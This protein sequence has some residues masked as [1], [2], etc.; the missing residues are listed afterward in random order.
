MGAEATKSTRSADPSEIEELRRLLLPRERARLERVERRLEGQVVTADQVGAVIADAIAAGDASHPDLLDSALEDPVSRAMRRSVRD[1]PQSVADALFPVMG[2]AIRRAIVE[3][4]RGMLESTNRAIEASLSWQGLQWRIEAWRS[5]RSFAEIVLL[6]SLIYRVEQLLLIHKETGLLVSHVVGPEVAAQHPDLVSAM[7]TAIRDFVRDSFGS[8]SG[9]TLHEF[10]VGER[11]VLVEDSPHAALAAVVRGHSPP[12][13]RVELQQALE[14]IEGRFAGAL[15]AFDGDTAPFEGTQRILEGSLRTRYEERR[16]RGRGAVRLVWLVALALAVAS[17]GWL[18]YRR[19]ETVQ[20][21]R[22]AAVLDQAPGL[23]VTGIGRSGRAF[24]ITGL[25]DPLA[26]DAVALLDGAGVDSRRARLV[27][28]PYQSLD[29]VIVARRLQAE[30]VAEIDALARRIE[31][32]PILMSLDSTEIL[33]ESLAWL[34]SLS[35]DLARIVELARVAGTPVRIEIIGHTDLSGDEQRNA[36]LSVERAAR[37]RDLLLERGL[38]AEALRV[39][40]V[41]ASAYSGAPD[42]DD[43][44]RRN[45]RVDVRVRIGSP[46]DESPENRPP[47]GPRG[48]SVP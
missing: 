3:T 17:I 36:L 28:E 11:E 19:A 45:R 15:A 40:G 34:P 9:D 4:V 6:H 42:S 25:R 39:Q 47:P 24:E 18:L 22:A 48:G 37:V 32:V 46:A 29:Q 27:L 23:V 38:P 2:P 31:A 33:P 12:E 44:L 26:D 7:L 5:G 30:H 10:Q 1:D 41:G 14:T 8:A 20:W 35:S 43:D 21:R 16:P 13:L